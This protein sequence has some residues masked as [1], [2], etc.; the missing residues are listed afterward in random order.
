MT[1]R[2]W[3]SRCDEIGVLPD[4]DRTAA[5]IAPPDEDLPQIRFPGLC[6]SV[7]ASVQFSL[8]QAGS[9]GGRL[10]AGSAWWISVIDPGGFR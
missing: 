8:P 4:V 10:R 7:A 5:V 3:P 2:R 6:R 1:L 9:F